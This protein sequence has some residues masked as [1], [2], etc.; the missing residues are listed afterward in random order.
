VT[1]ASTSILLRGEIVAKR[2]RLGVGRSDGV[3]E[4]QKQE[5]EQKEGR[6]VAIGVGCEV[7]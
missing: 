6:T 4:E 7:A 3:E 5:G 2:Q 1:G